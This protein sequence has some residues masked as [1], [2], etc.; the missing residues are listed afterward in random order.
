M[1]FYINAK[2]LM[3]YAICFD[4]D[5]N[6]PCREFEGGSPMHIAATNLCTEAV[7]VLLEHNADVT[8]KDYAG[9]TPLGMKLYLIVQFHH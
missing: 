4:V 8:L 7:K 6:S 9:R 2:T 5:I 3:F 1:M